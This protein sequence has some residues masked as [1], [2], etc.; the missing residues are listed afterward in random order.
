[1]SSSNPLS[2]R[3][4]AV[5]PPEHRIGRWIVKWL[6]VACSVQAIT[7]AIAMFSADEG[8]YTFNRRSYFSDDGW[9]GKVA[10]VVQFAIYPSVFLVILSCLGMA[11]RGRFF[12]RFAVGSLICFALVRV[13]MDLLPFLGQWTRLF[14]VGMGFVDFNTLLELAAGT[15]ATLEPFLLP[16]FAVVVFTRKWVRESLQAAEPEASG[17]GVRLAA[18]ASVISGLG[19]VI[20]S[21]LFLLIPAA[22]GTELANYVRPD[23]FNDVWTGCSMVVLGF[24]SV[25]ALTGGIFLLRPTLLGLRMV[26]HQARVS[27][28]VNSVN[29]FFFITIFTYYSGIWY[30]ERSRTAIAVRLVTLSVDVILWLYVGSRS[31]ERVISEMTTAKRRGFPL[32]TEPIVPIATLADAKIDA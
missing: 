5:V 2:Y 22:P 31:V 17:F 28:I 10:G 14:A 20:I 25:T 30:V 1:M 11:M 9:T 7:L 21:S 19:G 12:R 29:L 26:L 16:G 13:T 27:V 18:V 3:V 15:L 4:V 8:R 24:C 23:G 6:A 32:S